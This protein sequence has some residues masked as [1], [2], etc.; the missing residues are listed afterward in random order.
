VPV[1]AQGG[2]KPVD[3]AGPLGQHEAVTSSVTCR[4]RVSSA[5]RSR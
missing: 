5:T 1:T 2:C 3:V 4:V